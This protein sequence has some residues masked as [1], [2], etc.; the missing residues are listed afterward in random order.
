MI[1][2]L[3]EIRADKRNSASTLRE[4]LSNWEHENQNEINNESS[5]IFLD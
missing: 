2:V 1:T 5:D 4:K 3:P